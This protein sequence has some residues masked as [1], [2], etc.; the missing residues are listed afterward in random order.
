MATVEVQEY[1]TEDGDSPFAASLAG[2]RDSRAEARIAATVN[3]MQLGLFGD[4]KTAGGVKEA[5]IHYG[6]G[7][8]IYFGMDGRKLVILLLCGDKR[9]QGKDIEVANDYWKKY[10]ARK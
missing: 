3:K 5:R 7:Y 9:T 4:W 10:K 1:V 8:R 6:P 2:I